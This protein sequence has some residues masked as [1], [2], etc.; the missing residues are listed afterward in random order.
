MA[1]TTT[2]SGSTVTF[3]NSGAAANLTQ[4]GTEDGGLQFTFDV[5]AASGGGAK[6]TIYSV[7]DG[8]KNDDGGASITVTNKAFADYNKDLLIQ[9]QAGIQFAETSTNGA[10]FWIGSDNKIHYDATGLSGQI[11]A[12]AAGQTFIDT[13]QYTIKMS[14]GTL[15]VGT[16]SVVITGANDAP[17]VSA[18]VTSTASE[19]AAAYTID[20]LTNA[21]DVDHDAVLHIANLTAPLPAGLT[22]DAD[23][24]T[25][26]IAPNA[27]DA[28]KQGENAVLNLSYDVVDEHGASVA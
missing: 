7:D 8:I 28:L 9:D 20:L 5:L 15:S 19:D 16:L 17:T 27:Y 25:L 21:A 22:L 18:A 6:T 2:T 23:G 11:N 26:H 4:S 13:I 14:N 1:T 24:H 3:S 12:L 10:K